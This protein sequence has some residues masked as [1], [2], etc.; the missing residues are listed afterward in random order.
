MDDDFDD[1]DLDDDEEGGTGNITNFDNTSQTKILIVDDEEF[2][3]ALVKNLFLQ[4][5]TDKIECVE[6]KDG[7]EAIAK[8]KEYGDANPFILVF[9]DLNMPVMD[10]FE[11]SKQIMEHAGGHQIVPKI[12]GLT[13]YSPG[14]LEVLMKEK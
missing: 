14:E 8:V 3:R 13:S 4:I 10:G 5:C 12:Y 2:T 1:C 9:M 11:A 7:A 6:A